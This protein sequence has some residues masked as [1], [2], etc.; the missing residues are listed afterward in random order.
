MKGLRVERAKAE[1]TGRLLWQ[2]LARERLYC[3][4]RRRP[5][6]REKKQDKRK[7]R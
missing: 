3:P 4:I 5:H 2:K 7:D 6:P 1:K